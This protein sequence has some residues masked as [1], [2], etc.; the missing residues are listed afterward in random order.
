MRIVLTLIGLVQLGIAAW[1][2]FALR[3]RG[4]GMSRRAMMSL[5]GINLA[6]FLLLLTVVVAT[7]S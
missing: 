1:M 7:A 3:S 6:M 5:G 4:H 2:F